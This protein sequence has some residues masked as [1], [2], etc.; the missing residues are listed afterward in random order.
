MSNAN[1]TPQIHSNY[2]AL[3]KRFHPDLHPNDP[4]AQRNFQLLNETYHS[5]EKIYLT[6]ISISLQ[7]SI[8]GC[9]R[10]F[11][12]HDGHRRFLLSI[13]SGISSGEVIRYKDVQVDA[14]RLST[15]SVRISV[16][17]PPQYAIKNGKLIQTLR[18]PFL[19]S[20]F[21][22]ELVI[23]GPDGNR[24]RLNIPARAKN[25]SIYRIEHEGLTD[26]RSKIRGDLF[27]QI[28]SFFS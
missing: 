27:I 7:D 26:R 23:T 3:A 12:S 22:G 21:G 17:L 10:Y 19:K 11:V 14:D 24:L 25:K 15:L 8:L 28:R 20:L 1:L 18:I 6:R 4:N 13:P 5:I 9:D 2:R 16:D